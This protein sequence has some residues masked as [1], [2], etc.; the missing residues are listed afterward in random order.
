MPIIGETLIPGLGIVLA[1]AVLLVVLLRE[2]STRE[3]QGLIGLS[4]VSDLPLEALFSMKESHLH[5]MAR[6]RLRFLGSQCAALQQEGKR[7]EGIAAKAR[8]E[9]AFRV[10]VD[11]GFVED[12]GWGAYFPQPET[13]V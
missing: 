11:W 5:N 3:Q 6:S 8:F 1:G 7:A 13:A 10:Y 9:E 4:R 12:D 2:E